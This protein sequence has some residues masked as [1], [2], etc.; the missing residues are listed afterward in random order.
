MTDTFIQRPTPEPIQ[1]FQ[2]VLHDSEGPD[3][4]LEAFGLSIEDDWELKNRDGKWRL[5]FSSPNKSTS[6]VSVDTVAY[7]INLIGMS[8]GEFTG[9]AVVNEGDWIVTKYFDTDYPE[10]SVLND[11]AFQRQYKPDWFFNAT[12]NNYT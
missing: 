5:S 11:V 4:V 7:T 6:S 9:Q 1:A 8:T 3:E 2:A 12:V 10:V